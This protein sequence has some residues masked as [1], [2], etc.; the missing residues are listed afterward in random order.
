MARHLAY[1]GGVLTN[2]AS[3]HVDMLEWFFGDVVSVHARA[4]TALANI[5]TEDT[6]VAD[7]QAAGSKCAGK[8]TL[9][10]HVANGRGAVSRSGLDGVFVAFMNRKHNLLTVRRERWPVD[11]GSSG[12][13][14]YSLRSAVPTALDQPEGAIA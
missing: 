10:A 3:H 14:Y 11:R 13:K 6:A 5:K 2:Q 7:I 8:A 1:D 9:G 4:V 12:L